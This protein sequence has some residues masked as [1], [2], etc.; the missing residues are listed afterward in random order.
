MKICVTSSYFQFH[1]VIRYLEIS[2]EAWYM[3]PKRLT[4]HRIRMY[5]QLFWTKSAKFKI[6]FLNE[7]IFTDC[8]YCPKTK[9]C[10]QKV[11]ENHTRKELVDAELVRNY[12]FN[13]SFFSKHNMRFLV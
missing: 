5:S 10:E 3:K 7:S 2:F 13:K 4:I 1:Y 6:N 9:E 8:E 11:G 12:F